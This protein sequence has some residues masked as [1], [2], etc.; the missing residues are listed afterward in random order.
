M[1]L[2]VE[3]LAQ[4]TAA[5]PRRADD[6]AALRQR[7][8]AES[9]LQLDGP[10]HF[11][12]RRAMISANAR[13]SADLALER[14][15][16]TNDLLPSNYL[17]SGHLHAR[18]VGRIRYL[19]RTTRRAAYA[20]GFMVTPELMITNHHVFPVATA[21]EFAA[22]AD[23]AVIEFGYEYDVLGRLQEP[24][25]HALDPETFLH[26]HA[27]L[28]LA[29]VAVRPLDV[30]GRRPLTDQGYLVL[31][32][33]LGKA[34]AGDY[35]TIVQHPDGREKQVALRNN[36]IVDNSLAD[37][38][39][40]QSDTAP[41]SSGAAV[42]NNEW[43]VIALHSAGVARQD[44]SGNYLDR[45]GQIIPVENGRVDESRLVWL[46]NRGIRVSAIV[47][48]LLS[49]A[50]GV[51][52]HPLIQ[53][54]RSPAYTNARPFTAAALPPMRELGLTPPPAA[55]PATPAAPAPIEIR[56]RISADQPVAVQAL[57]DGAAPQALAYEKKAEDE[58]DYSACLGYDDQFMGIRLPLPAPNAALRKKLARR[59]DAPAD[60]VL[61][62]HHFSTLQ[63]A[64]RRVPV[65][66]AINVY[67]KQRYAELDDSTRKDRWLRDNRIDYDAQLDDAWYAKSGFDRG[68]LS[69]REDAEWG[70]TLAAAKTA[71]DM[72]CSYA[73][74]V[75]QVPAFN[76]AIMGYHGQWG[77]LEQ[78]LLEQGVEGESGKSA[79]ICVYSGPI[80]LNDDPVYASVQV[81]L[82]CFKVVA[83]FD[84][85]GAL[86]A[87]GFRLSQEK[88]VDGIDFEVLHF[89]K[90][91]KMQRKPLAW[92][93]GATGLAFPQALRD[94]DTHDAASEAVDD[95][96]IERLLSLPEPMR[97]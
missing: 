4:A 50:S 73:N 67:G 66:S 28:D 35:A 71:A 94:A 44:A 30:G 29:L 79:R 64:V 31:D 9:A 47:A 68:H 3:L 42:F 60:F 5:Y 7:N 82:S 53:T 39:I 1:K 36:E 49:P 16:G 56:I 24:V 76:R 12:R 81:A 8:A 72:T 57:T 96:A 77:R 37:V 32:G 83:W 89:D 65:L 22:F 27:A 92:I 87:T 21:A 51:D 20:T 13:E 63:H 11:A 70:P 90:L 40:Y 58:Q 75:P 95:D 14:Y 10:A 74:A 38:L 93:E 97:D 84:A 33:A 23:G 88:L 41:G 6:M 48:Y 45:D 2:P 25:A 54:L 59:G 91:F 15:I 19:D 86:R 43:Q 26:T 69:R 17:L 55:A 18:A 52:P 78:M 46:S 62:Y 61:K 85:R 80:F 34:G